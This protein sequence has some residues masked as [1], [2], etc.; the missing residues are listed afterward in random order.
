[1]NKAT[2]LAGIGLVFLSSSVQAA[3]VVSRAPSNNVTCVSGTC[4]ATAAN[5]VLDVKDVKKLLAAGDLAIKSGSV[6]MDIEVDAQLTWSR[7]H[8]LTFDA[9]RSIVIAQPITSEGTGGVTLVTND[10]GSGGDYDFTDKGKIAFWDV[11]SNL[12]INGTRFALINDLA[13]L[14]TDVALNPSGT[15]ALARGY[16]A[17]RDRIYKRPVVMTVFHGSFEGLGH[18]VMNLSFDGA[19]NAG[20][21]LFSGIAPEGLIRDIAIVNAQATVVHPNNVGMLA[22]GN[23]GTIRNATAQA[24][25]VKRSLGDVG[26]LVGTNLGTIDHCASAGSIA[27][28]QSRENFVGGLVGFNNGAITRSS[29]SVAVAGLV[30]GGLV[31]MNEAQGTISL[32]QATGRVAGGSVVQAVAPESGGLVGGNRGGIDRSFSTGEVDG[33]AGGVFHHSQGYVYVG[34]LVGANEG[35]ATNSYATGAVSAGDFARIGGFASFS[36]GASTSYSTGLVSAGANSFVGGFLSENPGTATLDYFDTDTAGTTVACTSGDCS[37]VTGLTSAQLQ[38]G[39]PTG[40]DPAIWGSSPSV[41]DG[42]P[43]LLANT[44]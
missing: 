17:S 22:V 43:Y 19:T 15:F 26:A 42:F 33:G 4:T 12:F 14:A 2:M 5:A 18:A 35:T 44:P 16:D 37:G 23:S 1:M 6:A 27:V 38:S 34:G 40:F 21:G 24:A 9:F 10:G 39:L 7:Q 31:G 11:S 32:S 25:I 13:T 3:L 28:T 20:V 8:A 41:N 29:S 36:D 30:S